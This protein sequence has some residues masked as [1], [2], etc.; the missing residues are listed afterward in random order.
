MIRSWNEVENDEI[1]EIIT[2]SGF[3]EVTLEVLNTRIVLDIV[4]Q[5]I[6]IW[7]QA[8]MLIMGVVITAK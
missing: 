2:N 7:N 8:E 6:R 1:G 3:V 5:I 4:E